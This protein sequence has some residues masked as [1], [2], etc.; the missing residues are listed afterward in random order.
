LRKLD[1]L[2]V[3]HFEFVGQRALLPGPALLGHALGALFAS[4][5]AASF[6]VGPTER[7]S[8]P[9]ARWRRRAPL[10]WLLRP[11]VLW[12]CAALLAG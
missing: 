5:L 10:R 6:W 9:F 1:P 7:V 3:L 4:C 11:L 12:S 2:S 8:D